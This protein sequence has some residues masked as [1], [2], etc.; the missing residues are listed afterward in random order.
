ML[1][2]FIKLNGMYNAKEEKN[3]KKR[4]FGIFFSILVSLSMV[5]GSSIFCYADT[6][7]D[8]TKVT[9]NISFSAS[10]DG[11]KSGDTAGLK[12][13]VTFV[14]D[15][16]E[17]FSQVAIAEIVIVIK[18]N[19]PEG[20]KLTYP[21][22]DE[23]EIFT[24]SIS[25][26]ENGVENAFKFTWCDMT[27]HA[28]QIVNVNEPI[29]IGTLNLT[30][31]SD[32]SVGDKLTFLAD[33]EPDEYDE[34]RTWAKDTEDNVSKLA[35]QSEAKLEYLLQSCSHSNVEATSSVEPTCTD[36]GNIAS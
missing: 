30:F 4:F 22:F 19:S 21:S 7:G 32:M 34:Y 24:D 9:A 23:G 26:P 36:D 20:R 33:V 5:L 13:Y 17:N 18:Y 3:M 16:E 14:P 25:A 15:S 10:N 8:I 29:C 11:L 6:I 12:T 27:G 31:N 1:D 2:L 28:P 35:S